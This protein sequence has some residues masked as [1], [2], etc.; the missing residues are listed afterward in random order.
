MAEQFPYLPGVTST[1]EDGGLQVH[2]E[3]DLGDSIVILGTAEKGPLNNPVALTSLSEAKEIFGAYG[4][5]T[6]VRGIFEAFGANADAKDVRGCRIGNATKAELRFAENN[7]T[8]AQYVDEPTYETDGTT[9]IP[10]ALVIEALK[11]G[12]EY[13]NVSIRQDYVDGALSIVIYN[14][15][16]GVES[17]FTYNTDINY[18]ADVHN[19]DELADAINADSNLKEIIKATMKPLSVSFEVDV[20]DTDQNDALATGIVITGENVRLTLS[21][22]LDTFI[23]GTDAATSYPT[24]VANVTDLY[25]DYTGNFPTVGNKITDVTS[26]YQIA[27]VPSTSG[28]S[29]ALIIETAGKNNIQLD[30][31]PI[32]GDITTT[33]TIG[34][35]GG[36]AFTASQAQ[37]YVVNGF[38][39]FVESTGTLVYSWET[40]SAVTI[41][42]NS[43]VLYKTVGGT[44]S[45]VSSSDF[46]LTGAGANP[47]VTFNAGAVPEVG[48]ILTVDYHSDAFTLTEVATRTAV[49]ATEDWK[50]YFVTGN[51][52]YFG[53][54]VPTDMI[55]T[56]QYKNQFGVGGQVILENAN[57]GKFYWPATTISPKDDIA[58]ATRDA[59]VT[60]G[61]TYSY[62]PEWIVLGFNA[63][64][65]KGGS[66]G[67]VMTN[68][69]KYDA[70]EAAL[71]N[72]ENYDA[73]IFVPMNLY[74]DDTKEYYNVETG[75]LE[76]MNA[77][78]HTLLH[79]F[80]MSLQE[81]VNEAIG[82]MSVKPATANDLTTV[83][84][85]YK[86]LTTVSTS[87]LTRGANIM[88]ALDSKFI[89]V[90]AMEPLFINNE[91]TTPYTSTGEAVYAGLIS[92]LP[93]QSSTTNKRIDR[94]VALRYEMSN[95]QLNNL[96][97]KRY[98]TMRRGGT[99]A[100]IVVTDGVTA[101]AAG[102]DFVRLSTVRIVF[103]AMDVVREVSEPFIGE[104]NDAAERQALDTAI[105]RGLQQMVEAK[106]LRDFAFTVTATPAEMVQGIVNVEMLLVP[107]FEMRKIKATVKLRPSL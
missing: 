47:D 99:P 24:G 73:D 45:E 17:S 28:T 96:S 38:I 32:Q 83:N 56:Y 97:L 86:K 8:T 101:A 22:R 54:T 61:F 37:Q 100:G 62:Q 21:E 103:A 6:L 33:K 87:D 53:T 63:L 79:N 50:N 58:A 10:D 30:E 88:S 77:G 76:T 82:V 59:P 3:V 26:V 78:Y 4:N 35:I 107:A 75:E 16:T 15:D 93:P 48:T 46:T 25:G 27:L 31:T 80:L 29:G 42:D 106:A 92:T 85:W 67:V 90:T 49:Q 55:I 7:P 23:V 40:D 74:L 98:V 12:D 91:V 95:S 69:E 57:T 36:N 5:G 84:D 70:L 52:I 64:S 66:D 19:V 72:L 41:T 102:S 71:D 105:R 13:N 60:L 65:L 2:R 20:M 39:G 9:Q 18:T 68:A 44:R 94:V 1:L 14:P 11:E 51:T 104:P 89:S 81:G 34:D 43:F